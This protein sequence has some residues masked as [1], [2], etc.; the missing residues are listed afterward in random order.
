MF[1]KYF[2]PFVFKGFF[3]SF[4]AILFL[5]VSPLS[6]ATQDV[7]NELANPNAPIIK[8]DFEWEFV[9][10]L[11]VMNNR[12]SFIDEDQGDWE[13]FGVGLL[14]D[15][16]YK[17]FFLQ[18][19]SRRSF[20]VLNGA[21]FGY[22]LTVQENWQLDLLIKSY[23]EGYSI[24]E[25]TKPQFKG[26]EDREAV[27]GI[28]LRYTRYFNDAIFYI[29]FAGAASPEDSEGNYNTG[30]I[31]DSFYS[32]LIPYRNWDIYLGAGLTYYNKALADYTFGVNENE[33]SKDRPFYEA[34]N[35]FRTQLELFVQYP[36]SQ[37]WSFNG[38]ITQ[39]FYSNNITKSPLVRKNTKTQVMLGVAYVF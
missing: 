24:E 20:T 26:L 36:I 7:G 17:G 19:N 28:A 33:V 27:G 18:T 29:D 3:T 16:S 31:I 14:L 2:N 15:I 38:G 30:V 21:E 39:T 23:I 34:D 35:T 32:Y 13:H 6:Y 12:V 9:I 1:I 25:Q 5:V 22:Q 8:N 10:D 37:S 11:S 4:T